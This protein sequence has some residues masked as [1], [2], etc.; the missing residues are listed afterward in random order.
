M[1]LPWRYKAREEMVKVYFDNSATTK[2]DPRV[3]EA[4]MPFFTEEYG[5]PSSLHHFGR[6]ANDALATARNQVA[7]AMGSSREDIIFTSGGTESDNIAIQ[8]FAFAN[9]DKGDHIITSSIEH[10]A[11]LH[12]CRFL[13]SQGFKVTYVPVNEEGFVPIEDLKS[14]INPRTILISV[15]AANNEIGVI[16]PVRDIGEICHDQGVAF[17]TDAVQAFTKMPLD[18]E[19]DNIDMLSISGHKFHG[20]KGVGALYVRRGLNIRPTMYGGGHEKGLRS[21]TENVSGIVG[22]GKAVEIAMTSMDSD[23]ERMTFLRDRIIDG[24]LSQIQ[25]SHF[26]G[27]RAKRLCNNAHFRFDFI[28]GESLV[29]E[30]D[31][32]GIA[33]STGSACSTRS[34]DP[35]HVLTAIGLKP[36][37]ARGSLRVSISRMST[38]EE[39]DYFLEALPRAVVKLRTIS[40]LSSW[41]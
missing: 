3:L 30:L 18:I 27:S 39:V 19:R 34:R 10:H 17:H 23:I 11:V 37:L 8:G 33:T 21:S 16:Q 12:T 7:K 14:A 29:L 31:E 20:P 25:N 26:N 24:V 2:V 40:P 5:N 38:S 4:M 6:V 22:I 9:K 36:E 15:M 32:M 35:S 28:D 1:S 41:E 13:E